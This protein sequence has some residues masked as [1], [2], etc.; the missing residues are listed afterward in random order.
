MKYERF[1]ESFITFIKRFLFYS[2]FVL[3]IPLLFINAV[4]LQHHKYLKD[5]NYSK[6][7]RQID[8]LPNEQR[9]SITAYLNNEF[10]IQYKI[11]F[12]IP[13]LFIAKELQEIYDKEFD[14]TQKNQLNSSNN[15]PP[16]PILQ[17]KVISEYVPE[18]NEEILRIESY[19]R[20]QNHFDQIKNSQEVQNSNSK[21]DQSDLINKLQFTIDSRQ[22]QVVQS[23]YSNKQLARAR[24]L[25]KDNE[26]NNE[27]PQFKPAR[28]QTIKDFSFTQH[29]QNTQNKVDNQ[30]TTKIYLLLTEI[31]ILK[32]CFGYLVGVQERISIA[33]IIIALSSLLDII[34][35]SDWMLF[36]NLIN[37]LKSLSLQWQLI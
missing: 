5:H 27:S 6:I 13:L 14:D 28:T 23:E 29:T 7:I 22:N 3:V 25:G 2:A 8:Q 16:P 34:L 36:S 30:I 9:E 31:A 33:I 26:Q 4:E 24:H 17:P 20:N 10:S 1:T 11:L 37:I 18:K 19:Y 12:L 15:L 32:S 21:F 35:F